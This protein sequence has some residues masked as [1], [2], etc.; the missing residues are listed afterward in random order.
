MKLGMFAMPLHPPGRPMAETLE[1]DAD[2]VV[3]ADQLELRRVLGRR[4][5]SCT[6]PISAPLMFL[7][8]L[9]HRTR[10]IKFGTG[11]IALP[12][13]HPAVVAAEVAQFDHLSR[14]RL[15]F[16]IG[17][18]GL[19]SDMELFKVLDG[20]Y[21]NE[22]MMEA[23]DTILQLWRQDPPYDIPG[24]HWQISLK[25]IVIPE[26][27]V[28]YIPKP[29]QRPHPEITMTAMSPYSGSVKVA[30]ATRFRSDERQFL[31]GIC[32]QTIGRSTR[33]AASWPNARRPARTGASHATSSSRRRTPRP[34]TG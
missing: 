13:H 24:K 17:P 6:E 9:I 33:K 26:L 16:G 20:E 8:S 4:T 30:A 10:R 22:R 1:E 15:M 12:N 14:G 31:P 3:Y 28:G 23:I 18:G 21:R 2:K 11:V 7:A 29:Y 34:A 19:A 32:G 25:D 5:L 27:G